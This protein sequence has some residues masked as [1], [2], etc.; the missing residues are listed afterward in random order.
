MADT[1]LER[2]T[3]SAAQKS[4]DAWREAAEQV[5]SEKVTF[6]KRADAAQSEADVLGHKAALKADEAAHL[7]RESETLHSAEATLAAKA[8]AAA[9][10]PGV[11][12]RLRSGFQS[13]KEKLSG[14]FGS[15]SRS[16]EET[17]DR[18]SAKYNEA[19]ASVKESAAET[20]ANTA[21]KSA[22]TAERWKDSADKSRDKAHLEKDKAESLRL[23]RGV[24]ENKLALDKDKEIRIDDSSAR[25]RSPSGSTKESLKEKAAGT[26]ENAAELVGDK[27]RDTEES[28]GEHRRD[29]QLAQGKVP[30]RL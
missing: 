16:V 28:M 8:D 19:V 24:D 26:I 2:V 9:S 23:E 30:E 17:S 13:M 27:A 14:T 15:A 7:R 11:A 18:A 21:N 4:G 20:M 25:E 22:D 12:D 5:G 29:A 10:P 1:N 6:E 3:Q